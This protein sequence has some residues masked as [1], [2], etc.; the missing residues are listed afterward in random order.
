MRNAAAE[1]IIDGEAEGFFEGVGYGFGSVEQREK[2]WPLIP[3]REEPVLTLLNNIFAREAGA[4][5]KGNILSQKTRCGQKGQDLGGDIGKAVLRPVNRV[6][7]VDGNDETSDA[8]AA[9][10]KCVFFRLAFKTGFETAGTGVDDEDGE[11]GLASTSD[12]VGNEVPV[13]RGV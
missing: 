5:H 1:D 10:Q 6:K 3:R 13:A 2:W 8:H 12:H 4:G 7:F 9:D 11:V